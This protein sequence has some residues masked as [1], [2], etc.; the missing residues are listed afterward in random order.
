MKHLF[1]GGDADGTWRE[2]RHEGED[3]VY[4][5]VR[6]P[7]G[8]PWDKQP[9]IP[10]QVYIREQFRVG[11]EKYFIYRW[12]PMGIEGTFELLLEGYRQPR[13]R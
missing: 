4:V 12:A 11:G 1:I 13:S 6:V 9:D 7:M 10:L 5:S 8:S 2:I 3:R